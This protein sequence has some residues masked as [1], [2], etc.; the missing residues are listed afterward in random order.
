MIDTLRDRIAPIAAELGEGWAATPGRDRGEEAHFAGPNGEQI[1]VSQ[2]TWRKANAGRLFLRGS[3]PDELTG[4]LY[5]T[6]AARISVDG[7]KPPA[8][9]A[10]DIKRRLLPAYREALA[11]ARERK[12]EADALHARRDAV[13]AEVV[14]AMGDGAEAWLPS[15]ASAGRFDDAVRADAEVET[16]REQ[17]TFAVTVPWSLAPTVA[18]LVGELRAASA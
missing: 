3:F 4:H 16:Y 13:M 8:V 1:H 2:D 7:A 14:A 17:A 10:K 18:R 5:G 12:A 11:V 15:K 6:P 9:I